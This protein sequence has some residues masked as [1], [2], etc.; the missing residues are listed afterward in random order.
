[1]NLSEI[2]NEDFINLKFVLYEHFSLTPIYT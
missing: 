1:M 2:E